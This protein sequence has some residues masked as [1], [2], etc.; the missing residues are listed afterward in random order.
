MIWSK[1]KLACLVN[2]QVKPLCYTEQDTRDTEEEHGGRTVLILT[3]I[4]SKVQRNYIGTRP[5]KNVEN[6]QK[7]IINRVKLANQLKTYFLIAST[8]VKLW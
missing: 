1:I 7:I 3:T 4:Q 5:Y 8:T 6:E 2:K